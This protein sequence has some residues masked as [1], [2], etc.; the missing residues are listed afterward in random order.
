MLSVFY[1]ICLSND[2]RLSEE[3]RKK[4]IT[5]SISANLTVLLLRCCLLCLFRLKIAIETD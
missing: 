2:T 3:E 1:A 5:T 4:I